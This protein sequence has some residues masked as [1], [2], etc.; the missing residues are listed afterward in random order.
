MPTAGPWQWALIAA[1]VV[2]GS[3]FAA[4]A[5]RMAVHQR[6][7]ESRIGVLSAIGGGLITGLAVGLAVLF[8]QASFEESQKY[9]AWR[10]NVEAAESIPGF[11]PG[12]RDIHE[13][14][15]SGKILRDAD[16]TGVDLRGVKFR[17][18]VLVGAVFDGANLQ[19]AELI[20]ADLEATSFRKADLREA[21]LQS[22]DFTHAAIN[23]SAKSFADAEVNARTCWPKDLSPDMLRTVEVKE[24]WN[25][26]GR[27]ITPQQ[28][29]REDGF[30]GGERAPHCHPEER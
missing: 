26:D 14:N 25:R 19:G 7:T 11:S 5:W 24:F 1:L 29:W 21:K 10:A 28:E 9:A 15:F 22:A 13:I 20:G 16:F 27:L 4:D 17:D 6:D 18:A 8:L 23:I 12:K 3:L 30:R 2:L